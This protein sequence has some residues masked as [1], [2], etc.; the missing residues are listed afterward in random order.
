VRALE[1]AV[2]TAVDGWAAASPIAVAVHRAGVTRL[3]GHAPASPL[4]ALGLFVHRLQSAGDKTPPKLNKTAFTLSCA[5]LRSMGFIPGPNL[6]V[7]QED[8]RR[9]LDHLMHEFATAPNPKRKRDELGQYA[10][11]VSS[12]HACALA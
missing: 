9:A 7:A 8:L 11:V 2:S 10:C 5:L 3:S 4:E 1:A 12:M 6:V